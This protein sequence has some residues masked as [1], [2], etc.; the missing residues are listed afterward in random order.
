MGYLTY[1]VEVTRDEG[2]TFVLPTVEI[3][4]YIDREPET[5]APEFGRLSRAYKGVWDSRLQYTGDFETLADA[6]AAI[7]AAYPDVK[8]IGCYEWSVDYEFPNEMP[9]LRRSGDQWQPDETAPPAG[10]PPQLAW[11]TG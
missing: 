11:Q 5:D 3:T 4:A 6:L 9:P 7:D 8:Q 10:P 1:R 2:P